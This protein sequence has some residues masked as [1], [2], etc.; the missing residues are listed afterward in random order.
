G[1][2]VCSQKANRARSPL[3]RAAMITSSGLAYNPAVL[4]RRIRPMRLSRRAEPFDSNEHIFELKID[5]FRAGRCDRTH[6]TLPLGKPQA[7]V[8]AFA[9]G[10]PPARVRRSD[11]YP[12]KRGHFISRKA[13]RR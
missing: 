13:A 11:T 2:I 9:S 10:R 1:E 7:P 6:W 3:M 8:R 5:G 12:R 4:P